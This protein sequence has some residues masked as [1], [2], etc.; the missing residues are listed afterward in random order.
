[1][2]GTA[3]GRDPATA[4]ASGQNLPP[5]SKKPFRVRKGFSELREPGL[6]GQRE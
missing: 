5:N 4:G 6:P 1:L 2:V 3:F